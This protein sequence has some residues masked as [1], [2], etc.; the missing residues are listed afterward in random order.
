MLCF[1]GFSSL[2]WSKS[3]AA[4]SAKGKVLLASVWS[5]LCLD[6]KFITGLAVLVQQQGETLKAVND[7]IRCLVGFIVQSEEKEAGG[8]L[9]I[10][11]NRGGE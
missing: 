4:V 7:N 8:K 1:I 5:S 11:D 3:C 10:K 9:S 2:V 6:L